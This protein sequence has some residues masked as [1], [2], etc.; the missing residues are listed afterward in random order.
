M[1][2]KTPEKKENE[3]SED[4][5]VVSDAESATPESTTPQEQTTTKPE[6]PVPEQSPKTE[7]P[8]DQK[9]DVDNSKTENSS[10]ELSTVQFNFK[11]SKITDPE[12]IKKLDLHFRN[13][14]YIPDFESNN[15]TFDNEELLESNYTKSAEA[16]G[17]QIQAIAIAVCEEDETMMEGQP[18][19]N[20]ESKFRIHGRIADG[21]HRYLESKAVGKDWRHEYYRVRNFEEFM[22]LR[23]HMDIK[24]KQK[25]NEMINK[26]Q[27]I[28][29][30]YHQVKGI[31]KAEVSAMVVKNYSP[32][33]PKSSLRS[34]ILP[35]YKDQEMVKRREGKGLKIE[36]TKKGKE[37]AEK[38]QKK[39][40][41]KLSKK[42]KTIDQLRKDHSGA[43]AE[44][45]ELR[46][47]T[48]VLEESV[49]EYDDIKPFL[50][51]KQDVL[52]E[53][54]EEKVSVE[55]DLKSKSFIVK[56]V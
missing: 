55:I 16:I 50:T 18:T 4:I 13:E 15:D 19:H 28:C 47:Q 12:E 49:K 10:E 38:I 27:Q 33:Y 41:K 43:V 34:W 23:S 54:T 3:T 2:I 46:E 26:F 25:G 37:V 56:K 29:E 11:D 40:D 9:D 42:D 32:P 17:T 44:A 5:A 30:F 35:E 39:A 8:L 48:K 22:L 52:V 45:N 53:G 6:E 51:T 31:P 21:R 24:K 1:E 20:P 14:F 36:D 7:T